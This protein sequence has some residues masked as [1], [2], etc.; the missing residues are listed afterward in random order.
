MIKRDAV[1][2]REREK[3]LQKE[4]LERGWNLLDI[5]AKDLE[6]H[7]KMSGAWTKR[8]S[9]RRCLSSSAKGWVIS[10]T[11]VNKG[12]SVNMGSKVAIR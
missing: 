8:R 3:C 7:G 10:V 1:I 9:L 2:R 11:E 6:I 5:F 12:A 4:K